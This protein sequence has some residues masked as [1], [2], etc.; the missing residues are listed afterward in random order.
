MKKLRPSPRVDHS[1]IG[2][3]PVASGEITNRATLSRVKV[4][5]AVANRHQEQTFFLRFWY[6]LGHL[7]TTGPS[8]R[9]EGRQS[10][11]VLVGLV[12]LFA[13]LQ[14][15]QHSGT[16]GCAPT[17]PGLSYVTDG[18]EEWKQ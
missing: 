2:Q 13:R 8:W 11:L 16:H 15:H 18:G 12:A 9:H 7:A 5:F 1:Q 6:G 4:H 17:L 14:V 10:G 3:V